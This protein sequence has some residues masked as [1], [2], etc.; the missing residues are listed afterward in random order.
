[1]NKPI[2]VRIIRGDT[3]YSCTLPLSLPYIGQFGWLWKSDADR[4][5]IQL[6]D[7]GLLR[8]DECYWEE[9]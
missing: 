2:R 9:V 5:C 8:G 7:G 4:Y 3:F 6:D 1:M